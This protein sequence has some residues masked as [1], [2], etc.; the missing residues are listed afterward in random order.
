MLGSASLRECGLK[1]LVVASLGFLAALTAVSDASAQAMDYRRLPGKVLDVTPPSEHVRGGIGQMS[2]RPITCRAVPAA[3]TRRRI[4]DVA[5]QEWSYFGFPILDQTRLDDE[6]AFEGPSSWRA[7]FPSLPQEEVVRVA[8]SVAGYWAATPQGA[9]MVARQNSAWNGPW[10]IEGRWADPWSAAF[11]SWVM[12]ES[13]LG[14]TGQF[15]RAIAHW[16]YIDQAIRA[17][18]GNAPRAGFIAHD[19]GEKAVV[20]GDLLCSSRRPVYRSI[21]DRRRQMGIGA[22][23]HCDIVVKVDE[24][25]NRI[26]AIGGNVRRSVTLKL[27]PAVRG[28][29]GNLLAVNPQE[30]DLYGDDI[31]PMFAHLK[32]RAEAIEAGALDNSPTI[33]SLD[34][35]LTFEERHPAY[36]LVPVSVP[37]RVC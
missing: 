31:R 16:S 12:C 18:D 19:L 13:G 15:Q 28:Q 20:P 3:Q 7:R 4:V 14:D 29:N 26:Y 24:A 36:G 8:D 27:L 21:A 10:G 30:G 25:A 9:G 33:K 22:R 32:L 34:C 35:V 5:V 6:T 17:R 2:V 1:S 37:G 23:A 11:V